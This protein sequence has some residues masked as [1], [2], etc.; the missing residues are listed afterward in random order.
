[1]EHSVTVQYSYKE[2]TGGTAT[3]KTVT[4]SKGADYAVTYSNNVNASVYFDGKDYVPV[5]QGKEPSIKLSGKGNF[6]GARTT[7]NVT[8]DGKPSGSKL[9]FEIRPKNLSDTIVTVGDLPEKLAAQAPKI[10]VKDGT[11][12]LPSSQYKITKII[13]THGSDRKPLAAPEVWGLMQTR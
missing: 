11:K 7:E 1:M 12:V 5:R 3:E 4:L 9:T 10:T 8:S 13:K 2:W 6:T